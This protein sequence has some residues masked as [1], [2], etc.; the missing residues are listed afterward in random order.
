MCLAIGLYTNKS[1]GVREGLYTNNGVREGLGAKSL[2]R[3]QLKPWVY[4][5]R[6]K[7]L[8][9][10]AFPNITMLEVM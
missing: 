7:T 9:H 3:S 5:T 2:R 6:V 4:E 10:E 8:D 1:N